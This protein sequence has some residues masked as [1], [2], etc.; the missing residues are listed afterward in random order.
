MTKEAL[1]KMVENWGLSAKII[2]DRWIETTVGDSKLLLSIGEIEGNLY[3]M[4][5]VHELHCQ[6]V[7]QQIIRGIRSLGF[8]SPAYT[9]GSYWDCPDI[10]ENTFFEKRDDAKTLQLLTDKIVA[11]L[12]T[13]INKIIKFWGEKG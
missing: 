8:R 9:S 11:S 3:C 7:Y 6:T 10:T 1:V 5:V 13:E 12:T 2:G 4:I